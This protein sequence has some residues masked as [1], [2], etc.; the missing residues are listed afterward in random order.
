MSGD[1]AIPTISLREKLAVECN[2]L[3]RSRGAFARRCDGGTGCGARGLSSQE[4]TRAASGLPPG[5]LRVP[6][7]S[8]LDVF[9]AQARFA[10]LGRVSRAQ[11]GQRPVARTRMRSGARRRNRRKIACALNGASCALRS[12][13][14]KRG[15]APTKRVWRAARRP[16][17][18]ARVADTTT[19]CAFRRAIPQASRVR[20]GETA[21]PCLAFL[22]FVMPGQARR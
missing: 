17:R 4:S 16:P 1:G 15:S 19:D 14:A 5:P 18:A 20:P 10:H 2:H 6:A 11:G 22:P 7:R 21:L 9:F 8:W 3:V 12:S 13:S